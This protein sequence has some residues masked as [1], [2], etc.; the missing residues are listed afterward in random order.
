MLNILRPRYLIVTSTLVAFTACAFVEPPSNSELSEVQEGQK[1]IVLFRVVGEDPD[2]KPL[3][4]FG[5]GRVHFALG[6]PETGG[7]PGG[8]IERM[9]HLSV[10]SR[11]QGWAYLVLDPGTYYVAVQPPI[12]TNLFTY[13][14]GFKSAPRWVLEIPPNTPLV[15]AGTLELYGVAVRG[16]VFGNKIFV[17]FDKQL[18][19]VGDEEQM[20]ADLASK[21][22]VGLGPVTAVLMEPQH[23]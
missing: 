6:S 22:F 10:E 18:S 5:E 12:W 2:G 21:H 23:P 9:R 4:A 17:A 13:M 1:A 14:D 3:R 19:R 20:A 8:R 16:L 15:Y 7:V 11:D